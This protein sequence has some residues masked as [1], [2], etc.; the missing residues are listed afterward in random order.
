MR[1]FV[2][3]LW[4]YCMDRRMRKRVNG[5]ISDMPESY[6]LRDTRITQAGVMRCCLATVAEEYEGR[7]GAEDAPVS[8]GMK[9]KCRHCGQAFTLVARDGFPAWLPDWQIYG[10]NAAAQPAARATPVNPNSPE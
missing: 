2:D 1:N 3:M 10:R 8:L 5:E 7:D 9:S 4:L 6:P